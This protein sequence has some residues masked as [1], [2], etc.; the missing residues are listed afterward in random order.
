MKKMKL[1]YLLPILSATVVASLG[2]AQAQAFVVED[3]FG[4]APILAPAVPAL[5]PPFV[6]PRVVVV[7]RPP[8]VAAPVVVAPPAPFVAAESVVVAPSCP[9]GYGDC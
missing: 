2:S 9:Y 5:A 7:R 6:A 8:V 4:A 1:S 3:D